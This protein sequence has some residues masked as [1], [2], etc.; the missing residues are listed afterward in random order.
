MKI[1][2]LTQPLHNNY[3]G[4]L[5]NYALQQVL[6]GMGH[7]VETLDH[8]HEK[9][10]SNLNSTAKNWLAYILMPHRYTCPFKLPYHLS[11]K[12]DRVISQNTN[13]FIKKYI[14]T[15]D[16]I[17]TKNDFKRLLQKNEY[18]C[19]VVG[20]DQCWRPKYNVFL[21]EMFLSFAVGERVKRIAYA[22]SFGTKEWEMSSN[23]TNVCSELAKLFDLI[24]VREKDGVALCKENLSVDSY[25][26]LDPTMLLNKQDFLN[27]VIEEKE[28]QSNGNLF[29]YI[30]D[31]SS[32]KK[33]FINEL[34]RKNG[35]T[36]FTVMP[37]IA[38][39]NI[40]KSDIR[41]NMDNCI[42]PSVTKWLRAFMD[43]QVNVVDSFHGMVFSIIFNKPFWVL[44]N[45]ERGMSRFTSLLGEFG[46]T[47]RL[48]SE[49]DY[50]EVNLRKSIDWTKVNEIWQAKKNES[51]Q[52]LR[53]ALK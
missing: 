17:Y 9:C 20:S 21:E 6:K 19:L 33:D 29:Y 36:P 14:R 18:E 41:K 12:E 10:L 8:G 35:L 5:Q 26:V 40:Q 46:L 43:S 47:D 38:R 11:S 7:E 37:K 52:L 42:Y 34:A 2:I 31:P 39:E 45:K 22:V 53:N 15:S 3:G 13:Y 1:G 49:K 24:T 32:F 27:I 50:E 51:I 4:L 44:G 23:Q 28:L 48:V 25:H 16:A 30:L